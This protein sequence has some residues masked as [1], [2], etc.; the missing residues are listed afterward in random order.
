[1]KRPRSL[2][3]LEDTGFAAKWLRKIAPGVGDRG[4][5]EKENSGLGSAEPQISALRY[6]LSKN[7]DWLAL[8]TTADPSTPLRFGRDDKGRIGGEGER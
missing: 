5:G 6:A 4:C 7:T 2:N 8:E 3:A 1:M